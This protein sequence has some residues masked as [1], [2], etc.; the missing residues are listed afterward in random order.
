LGSESWRAKIDLIGIGYA[1]LIFIGFSIVPLSVLSQK[2]GIYEF[3]D[4]SFF[5]EEI[6]EE[7]LSTNPS[8]HES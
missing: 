3:Y 8:N 7:A 2:H 4:P 5:S 1:W 6:K